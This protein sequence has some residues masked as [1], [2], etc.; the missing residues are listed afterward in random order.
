MGLLVKEEVTLETLLV[1]I[2]LLRVSL[3]KKV[4][5]LLKL[6]KKEMQH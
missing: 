4:W 3:M 2:Q 1:E 5:E 6:S